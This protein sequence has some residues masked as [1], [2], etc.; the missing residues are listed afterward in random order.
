MTNVLLD[1]FPLAKWQHYRL[2]DN[3]DTVIGNLS[4]Q[5]PTQS[6]LI[7]SRTPSFYQ[8]TFILP[9]KSNYPQ[10]S[11]LQVTGWTK[12]VAFLNGHNLGRYWPVA[13]HQ[14]SQYAPSVFFRPYPHIN[15]IVLFELERSPCLADDTCT[16]QFVSKHIIN[17]TTPFQIGKN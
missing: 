1:K 12:G 15:S 2:Y 17:G 11:F 14:D 8:G 16:I 3:W 7:S 4:S 13:G 10:D 6:P 9:N 5:K